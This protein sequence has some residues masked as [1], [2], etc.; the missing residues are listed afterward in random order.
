MT[1]RASASFSVIPILC[2]CVCAGAHDVRGRL[3]GPLRAAMAHA[4]N[5]CVLPLIAH[6]HAQWWIIAMLTLFN[7]FTIGAVS[8]VA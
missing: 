8:G 6:A 4:K 5:T 3:I 1:E 7:L 2:F